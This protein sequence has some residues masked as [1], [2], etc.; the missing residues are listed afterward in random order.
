M[1]EITYEPVLKA[2]ER[3]KELSAD[4]ETRRLAFVRERAL[5]DEASLINDAEQRGEKKGWVKGEAN[6][7]TRQLTQRFGELPHWATHKLQGAS[8]EQ[9]ELWS[10][11]I[12]SAETLAHIFQSDNAH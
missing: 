12:F 7:L 3:L 4:E 9:L 8:A 10:D 5:H 2:M 11:N 6:L 1:A